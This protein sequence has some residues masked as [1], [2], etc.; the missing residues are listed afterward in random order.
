[1]FF[2]AVL[3]SFRPNR[4]FWSQQ[5]F[6]A[7]GRNTGII[8]Y[9]CLVVILIR[10]MIQNE[11]GLHWKVI[12]CFF[13]T[14]L[15]VN[16]YYIFQYFKLDFTQW[17]ETYSIPSSF[18]GNPN[19]VS[20]FAGIYLGATIV[21]LAE[22]KFFYFMKKEKTQNYFVGWRVI[23]SMGALTS[24][25][26]LLT[27]GSLQGK[28]VAIF[29]PL[30]YLLL[31]LVIR[32]KKT[33][34]RALLII[35]PGVLLV[36]I[37]IVRRYTNVEIAATLLS[38]YD[39]QIRFSYWR[40]AGRLFQDYPFGVGMD[41]LGDFYY[42]YANPDDV[43]GISQ[44]NASHNVALD[45]LV[46]GGIPLFVSYLI[47][48]IFTFVTSLKSIYRARGSNRLEILI[49]SIWLSFILQS[50]FSI[51]QITLA[52]WTFICNGILLSISLSDDNRSFIGTR[53]RS[54][55]KEVNPKISNARKN[56]ST[57]VLSIIVLLLGVLPLRSDLSF[58]ESLYSQDL[59][60]I[61]NSATNFPTNISRLLFA[62]E[63]LCLNGDQDGAVRLA[64]YAVGLNPSDVSAW[65]YLIKFLT[66]AY[67][68]DIALT[69]IKKLDPTIELRDPTLSGYGSHGT[70]TAN[71]HNS[72]SQRES[73]SC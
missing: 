54:T 7:Y 21:F 37:L 6:G 55:L 12:V 68:Q 23:N 22:R 10:F 27:N 38:R 63:T 57:S 26:V 51:N 70:N 18:L 66:K 52:F 67:D 17:E 31:M 39:L 5:F 28:V 53:E 40:V 20:V 42:R 48:I 15:S 62:S 32:L 33:S 8:F 46:G 3:S 36:I 4:E 29:L 11:R 30:V 59:R 47:L 24:T 69:E 41:S 73:R 65:I 1:M 13:M 19:F 9:L 25:F 2:V 35:I 71:S 43:G 16:V 72:V 64:N 45:F 44:V 58:R 56:I 61:E 60:K 34:L 50:L 14:G 49:F